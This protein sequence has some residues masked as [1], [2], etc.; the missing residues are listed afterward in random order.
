MEKFFQVVD[1]VVL[2]AGLAVILKLA[3]TFDWKAVTNTVK[4]DKAQL[5]VIGISMVYVVADGI[6]GR[7]L[8]EAQLPN[9]LL[10][11]GAI[12]SLNVFIYE[13]VIKNTI[14]AWNWIKVKF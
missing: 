7:G 9:M 12:V 3:K 10:Q 11:L 6:V 14:K 5:W 4:G 2:A 1:P 8:T 13:Y